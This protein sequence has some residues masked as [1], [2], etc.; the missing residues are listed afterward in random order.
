MPKPKN[1]TAD[2]EFLE[3]VES[4]GLS[5]DTVLDEFTTD[6]FVI[7]K[8]KEL[9]R[10]RY[11]GIYD[12]NGKL[13]P[14]EECS[15]PYRI[16]K[17]LKRVYKQAEKNVGK[18]VREEEKGRLA[19]YYSPLFA[20]EKELKEKYEKLAEEVEAGERFYTDEE[21][22]KAKGRYET[23]AERISI[24]IDNMGDKGRQLLAEAGFKEELG[25]Y[26]PHLLQYQNFP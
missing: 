4:S 10:K 1:I 2:R 22:E 21:L 18:L 16:N 19:A 9:Y 15:E 13:I 14:I 7:E 24:M 26:A 5:L 25:G 8:K 23:L 3:E 20:R 12:S 11:R 6:S 17:A